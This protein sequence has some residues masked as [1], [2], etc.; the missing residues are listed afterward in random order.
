MA[1]KV[2][3]MISGLMGKKIGMT[4]I[5]LEEGRAVPVTVLEVGPCKVVQV[6]TPE[7]DGYNAV[8]VG[9]GAKRE[10]G[11]NKPESGH[12]KAA[13]VEAMAHLKEFRV[14]DTSEFERGQTLG[15]DL[16]QIGEKVDIRGTSK[17]RGFQGVIKRWGFGGLKMTHGTHKV[18]RSPGSIGCSATPSKTIKNKKM[19]GHMGSAQVMIKNLEVVDVR[20]DENLIMVKGSVPGSINS[21]VT[22]HRTGA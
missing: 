2:Y 18:Q 6:K 16:F 15:A 3:D 7:T 5:F 19:P 9:F 11:V 13:G 8:Q 10:K 20:P 22:V 12:F 14:K 4:R 1:A 21:I 17:G